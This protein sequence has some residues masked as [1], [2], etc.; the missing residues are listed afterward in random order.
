MAKR[1]N[2]ILQGK[3]VQAVNRAAKLGGRSRYIDK[4]VQ[5]YVAAHGLETIR[6]Q[7]KQTALR[8]RDLAD[9]VAFDWFAV[10]D[11]PWPIVHRIE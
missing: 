5:Y 10:D 8:D 1:M 2:V 11:A 6:E 4:A 3:A 7:L 9:A